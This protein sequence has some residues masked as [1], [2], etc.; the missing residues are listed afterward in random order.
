MKNLKYL[1]IVY[2]F[3]LLV[4]VVLLHS[5]NI[6]NSDEGII[7]EGSWNMFNGKILYND[8][9]EFIT[10]GSFYFIYFIWTL[11][12]PSYLSAKIASLL[13]LYA[14]SFLIYKMSNEFNKNRYNF[15]APIIFIA[16]SSF[17]PIIN[18]NIHNLFFLCLASFYFIKGLKNNNKINFII[19]GL[20]AGLA[21]LFLQQKGIAILT[22]TIFY[23]MSLWIL[24]KNQYRLKQTWLFAL[25]ASIPISILFLK[26]S[27]HL[28]YNNL[29][30][31]SLENYISF[32]KLKLL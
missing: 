5:Q 26:W 10:P 2:W 7:L 22:T 12:S 13:L 25:S 8:F 11:F 23:L 27:A 24:E 17:W 9:F 32:N 18:H 28:L 1:K 30:K 29:I 4:L 3:F 31:F 16:S 14:S 15:I 19:S 6:L 20:S 21:I